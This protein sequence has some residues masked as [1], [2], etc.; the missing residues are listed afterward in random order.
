M[1]NPEF[2]FDKE[3]MERA[4]NLV[5]ALQEIHSKEV[6]GSPE[7]IL[8]LDGNFKVIQDSRARLTSPL[9]EI[10]RI[11]PMADV[12]EDLQDFGLL[13]AIS[14]MTDKAMTV[15]NIRDGEETV[16]VLPERGLLEDW[17]R[18]DWPFMPYY[19]RHRRDGHFLRGFAENALKIVS[20]K[21]AQQG[22]FTGLRT[23]L[24]ARIGGVKWLG[25]KRFNSGG[26]G[27]GGG[28]GGTGSSGASSAQLWEVHTPSR[29]GLS[30]AYHGTH[31]AR[32]PIALPGGFTTPVNVYLPVGTLYLGADVGVGGT[33]IFDYAKMLTVPYPGPHP[34]HTI[35]SPPI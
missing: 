13:A 15:L 21:E 10:S 25:S 22:F 35:S 20:L 32:T 29:S 11:I 30:V 31:A 3:S 16:P 18:A 27:G 34:V 8:S 23:F 7:R 9:Q 33:F 5:A 2:I 1:P 28:G 6:E 17:Q 12:L 4:A 14:Q 19:I 26:S 24:T